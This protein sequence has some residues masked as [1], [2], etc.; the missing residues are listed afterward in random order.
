MKRALKPLGGKAVDFV[1]TDGVRKSGG[2]MVIVVS[3]RKG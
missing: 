1:E 3:V 2:V